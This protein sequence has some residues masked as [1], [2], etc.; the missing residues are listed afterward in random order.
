MKNPYSRLTLRISLV[1]ALFGT[2]LVIFSDHL[3]YLWVDN[4]NRLIIFQT[5]KGIFYVTITSL[6]LYLLLRRELKVREQA[7]TLLEQE[8]NFI[9]AVLNIAGAL[10]VV[11]NREG[12]IIEFN[13]TCEKTTGYSFDE[14]RGRY[15]WDIFV[16]REEA[17]LVKDVFGQLQA[18][19]L[20]EHESYCVT[21]DGSRRLIFWSNTVLCD[22]KGSVDYVISIGIDVTERRRMEDELRKYRNYLEKLVKTRT[23]EL[24]TVNRQ[25]EQEITEH[26]RMEEALRESEKR[27]RQLVE[28]S[29]NAI[30]VHSKG[31]I[32]FI[33]KAGAQLLGARGIQELIGKPIM[34]FIHS[35]YRELVRERGRHIPGKEGNALPL[36]ELKLIR[37]DG[38]IVDVDVTG[39]F[40]TFQGKL[41]VQSIVR[42]ITQRKRAEEAL[43][44]AKREKE[45]ILS[46]VSEP[47]VYHDTNMRIIWANK[48]A[49]KS[50][51]M[52]PE[53][54]V[55]H[56]CYEIWNRRNSP[57]PGCP[58]KKLLET[59]EVQQE[60]MV[61]LD[62]I[63]LINFYPVKDEDNNVIGI[64]EVAQDITERKQIE[65]ALRL[66]KERF[67][68][69][70]KA[71]SFP[72]S[73]KTMTDR[74][75]IDVND[76]YLRL[77]GYRREEIIGRTEE[78]LNLYVN[79]EDR[80]KAVQLLLEQGG[81]RNLEVK[82]RS[83]S[84]EELIGLV[85]GEVIELNGEQCMLISF[86][87]IT[88][89][90]Q[91]EQEMVRLDRLNLIGE[92]A[93]GI[94]HEIRNPMTSVRGFVQMLKGKDECT[95]YRGY[96]DL[97]IEEVDR[98]NAI[99]TEYLSLAKNKPIKTEVQNL[100]FIIKSLLPLI[101]ADAIAC[102]KLIKVE[103][104][105]LPDLLLDKE[106]I[107]QL[108]LNLTRNGLEA[109]SPGGKLVIKTFMEANEVVLA[110]QDQGTG[111]KPDIIDKINTPF[112]TTKDNGTGLGLAICNS[113]AARH[114]ATIT[115][116]TSS[117]G[118]TFFVRF[119]QGQDCATV[120]K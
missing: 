53:Q 47:V 109:M 103:L 57:C 19:Q 32:I 24:R 73:I 9:S 74:R 117:K 1:Y 41:V 95:N 83:K 36:V 2:L 7:E 64:V 75:Y 63:W 39:V 67:S 6:L 78:E 35:D 76:S 42:D 49:G 33:N 104:E 65:E 3:L 110:V 38:L 77:T 25:L 107:R 48:S 60:E 85:S 37:L 91:L 114:N 18:G 90:K 116:E 86:N 84:G 46:T 96:F 111:I 10:I 71:S 66:S 81:M 40:L 5:Y 21:K 50:G 101:Q 28:F 29:P 22:N 82:I 62:G 31:K 52:A 102:D 99:V 34:D 13:R 105:K 26:K 106:E 112:F 93:A 79:P 15:F 12:R 80:A 43:R 45:L 11:L 59:G 113:I 119:K 98:V 58:V 89:R 20:N 92:M 88:E 61:R 56:Y 55:G 14:V 4:S 118:T 72:M 16:I 87:D 54:L 51:G 69:A 8:R 68:K 108:I 30:V 27:Y 97:I 115:L 120:E 17:E 70:F 100:N 44:K 94:A 23:S